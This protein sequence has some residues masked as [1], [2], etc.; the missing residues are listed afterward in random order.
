MH[1]AGL[2]ALVTAEARTVDGD[3][4]Y[5]VPA[6][7]GGGRATRRNAGADR[8]SLL[9]TTSYERA[10][11]EARLRGEAFDVDRGMPGSVVQP[12]LQAR[13][14]QRRLGLGLSVRG[15]RGPWEWSADAS[16]QWQ[17]AVYADDAPPVGTPYDDSVRVRS[18]V[19]AAAL[20]AHFPTAALAIGAESRRTAFAA[21]TL[22]ERAPPADRLAGVWTSAR[23]W[24]DVTFG[25][26]SGIPLRAEVQAGV[27][28]DRSSLLGAAQLSPRV[29][30]SVGGARATGRV[31]WGRAFSPP[32]LAD[33][34]FQEG[35]RARP[36]PALRPERV[37]DEVEGS[38]ELRG[39]LGPAELD[40]T[41]TAYRADV[42]GMILWFPDFRF[43]WSPQNQDVVRR[44]WEVAAQAGVPWAATRLRTAVS[45]ARVEYAGPVLAGQVAYRPALTATAGAGVTVAGV[46]ADLEVRHVGVRRVSPGTSVNQLSPFQVVDVRLA[47]DFALRDWAAELSA[48]VENLLDEQA[49]MLA[50]YPQAGRRWATGIRLRRG[51]GSSA[52]ADDRT[53]V[54]P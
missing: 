13:Q 48:G 35:V 25:A 28:A 32:S 50:D 37:R 27:R 45:H 46:R 36:N 34:F 26:R 8:R 3:F 5:D 12:S 17:R 31:T 42:E 4:T 7:R 51:R 23:V 24:R 15:E 11:F 29:G 39:R 1:G 2:G 22:A 30:V 54:D 44:G 10:A 52:A 14:E 41:G 49:A 38:L 19:A 53:A 40:A 43:V 20:T 6:V 16:E 18:L 9:A 47:R 21:T 33:Q